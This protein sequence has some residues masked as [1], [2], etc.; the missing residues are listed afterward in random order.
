MKHIDRIRNF[1]QRWRG[2]QQPRI[3]LITGA[4]F[5]NAVGDTVNFSYHVRYLASGLGPIQTT[6]WDSNG[7]V[8][9]MLCGD[10][11]SSTPFLTRA[12]ATGEHDLILFDWVTADE[13][14]ERVLSGPRTVLLEFPHGGSLRNPHAGVLRYKLGDSRWVH[15]S[16][17]TTMSHFRR[18]QVAYEC[19]GLAA[20]AQPVKTPSNASRAP[21]YINPYASTAEK[22]LDP[23]LLDGLLSA[24]AAS[25]DRAI[26]APSMPLR[27]PTDKRRDFKRLATIIEIA[28][29]RGVL[30]RLEPMS[31]A[32][33]IETIRSS[34]MAIG[35]DTSTQH[36]AHYY[37]VPAISCYPHSA[38]YRY[39]FWGCPGPRNL[40][41]STPD[42]ADLTN[43]GQLA[44][45]VSAIAPLIMAEE[46]QQQRPD[47]PLSIWANHYF[48]TLRAVASGAVAATVAMRNS[49]A[50]LIE[51][52]NSIP[53]QWQMFIIPELDLLA[54]EICLRA[55]RRRKGRQDPLA[56]ERLRDIYALKTMR[57][58][59]VLTHSQPARA[60][61]AEA[62][63][64]MEAM[65]MHKE[66]E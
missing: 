48:E 53:Q 34:G 66:R 20:T 59:E 27:I 46:E 41:F 15:L 33:Y 56:V 62:F 47:L 18:L 63:R 10:E 3:L 32:E 49:Q 23:N 8:W 39:Y 51:A 24:L 30:K 35:S 21:L 58:I 4:R 5:R 60:P 17:P 57:Y 36:I 12:Q 40:C 1:V 44:L 6:T 45:L 37:G 25:R 9:R 55:K 13:S 38:G 16:T 61:D 31:T 28:A 65:V 43:I 19:L 2:G 11:I 22:C 29:E 14:V 26:I 54:N 42:A 50:A 7:D 64:P 52:R